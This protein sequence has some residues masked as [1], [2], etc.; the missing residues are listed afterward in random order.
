MERRR[1]VQAAGAESRP[2]CSWDNGAFSTPPPAQHP[3]LHLVPHHHSANTAPHL[4]PELPGTQ[5]ASLHGTR[6]RCYQ[7]HKALRNAPRISGTKLNVPNLRS[8]QVSRGSLAEA[9]TRR[10]PSKGPG[11]SRLIS[12]PLRLLVGVG[13]PGK[14][15]RVSGSPTRSPTRPSAQSCRRALEECGFQSGRSWACATAP[16]QVPGR[17]TCFEPLH[18]NHNREHYPVRKGPLGGPPRR[19][20]QSKLQKGFHS[21]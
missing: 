11:S 6:S 5:K 19:G 21:L 8:A 4:R 14:A 17:L 18:I 12:L 10:P 3:A 13:R 1:R 16:R 9:S 20:L 15:L 7:G 2:H